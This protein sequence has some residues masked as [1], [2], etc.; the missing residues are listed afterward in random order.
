[1]EH[2]SVVRMRIKKDVVKEH[3][4]AVVNTKISEVKVLDYLDDPY[5]ALT[6]SAKLSLFKI[7]NIA[8]EGH[9][10]FVVFPEFYLPIAWILDLADFCVK[11]NITII[12][13]LQYATFNGIAFNNIC[14]LTPYKF[15]KRFN[16]G[17]LQFREKNLYAPKEKIALS[18]K[19]FKCYDKEVPIYFLNNF[20][21]YSYSSILCYEFTDIYSRAAMKSNIELLFVPQ[22][23]HD[24]N[25]F[26]AIVESAARDLHCFVIQANTSEYGDSRITAPYKTSEK[27]ILQVKGGETDVVMIGTV[28]INALL[29]YRKKYDLELN[30]NIEICFKC[31]N[32]KKQSAE[33]YANICNACKKFNKKESKIKPVP[34][35]FK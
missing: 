29:E 34:P 16:I 23:N 22:L 28:E 4:I 17:L 19:G 13:G 2:L 1:M 6:L 24:T 20:N 21:G 33:K 18:K 32:V 15:G 3:R 14:T 30:Q 11:N 7:L 9:A 5:E 10:E 27:N 12:T 31:D 26:S 8:K 35:K 25:Y